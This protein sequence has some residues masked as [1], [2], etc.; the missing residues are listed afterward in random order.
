MADRINV[1]PIT[2]SQGVAIGRNASAVVKG[3]NVSGDVRIDSD[4]LRA[5]LADLHDAL[6]GLD[7]ARDQRIVAET[8]AGNAMSG[9]TGEEVDA[10]AVTSN[11]ERVGEVLQQA[12]ALIEDGTSMWQHVTRLAALLGPVVGGAKVVGG[13]FGIPL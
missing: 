11:L 4:Q 12:D 1:G 9:V 2:G 10:E 13:W 7:L 5:A 3:H 8:A 6:R